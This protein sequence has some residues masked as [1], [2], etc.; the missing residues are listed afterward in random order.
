[1]IELAGPGAA[2]LA[3]P[4]HPG[5]AGCSRHALSSRA[6][7]LR[8]GARLPRAR[9][10]RAG[11]QADARAVPAPAPA[12]RPPAP[13]PPAAVRRQLD[14]RAAHAGD[15]RYAAGRRRSRARRKRLA[16][17]RCARGRRRSSGRHRQRVRTDL[18]VRS[19]AARVAEPRRP[20]GRRIDRGVA[21]G[22]GSAARRDRVLQGALR[23]RK[24]RA[25]DAYVPS[26]PRSPG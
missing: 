1:V 13:A 19:E 5:S 20:A 7:L 10:L 3:L 23:G 9:R 18:I 16:V 24:R 4:G 22:A 14:G 11:P 8:R 21:A 2:P 17:L 12:R 26:I 25:G 15:W 6:F